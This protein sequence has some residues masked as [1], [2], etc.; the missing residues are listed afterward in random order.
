MLSQIIDKSAGYIVGSMVCKNIDE[1][2]TA[3][4]SD[5]VDLEHPGFVMIPLSTDDDTDVT[6][7]TTGGQKR[8]FTLTHNQIIPV[9]VKR[10]WSTGTTASKVY[11]LY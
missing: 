4:Y 10:I 3:T 6:V 2:I 1:Y 7:T 9:L 5:T 8:T 11:L